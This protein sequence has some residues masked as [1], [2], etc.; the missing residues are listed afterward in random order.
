MKDIEKLKNY[1]EK[2]ERFYGITFNSD[3]DVHHIDF[4]RTNNDI[5][6]LLLLPKDLH[7]KY[8][9]ILNA[10]GA[11]K[12][13][14]DLSLKNFNMTEYNNL[15][16]EKLPDVISECRKWQKLKEYRYSDAAYKMIFKE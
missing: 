15:F 11:Y 9:M 13:V 8:H 16:F 10:I 7:A 12:G 14:A 3:F 1:R 5:K 4:D 2:Y 6:N